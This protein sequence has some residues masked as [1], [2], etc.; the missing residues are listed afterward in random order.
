VRAFA[1]GE[2]VWEPVPDQRDL[3]YPGTA[4]GDMSKLN[5]E[6]NPEHA[7]KVLSITTEWIKHG[8]AK[9]AATLTASG[10]VSGLL[11][12][13]AKGRESVDWPLLAAI[14]LCGA[15]AIAGAIA[16]AW[17]L[18]P[19]IW[20]KNVAASLMYFEHIARGFTIESGAAAYSDSLSTLIVDKEKLVAEIAHQIWSNSQVARRKFFWGNL[21]VSLM[22][23]SLPFLA[24]T[25]IFGAF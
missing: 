15:F 17:A 24:L 16:A 9:A 1:L 3:K 8:E 7:W 21:G 2:R 12:N 18:K 4:S 25:A 11:Y 6:I 14:I 10:L 13:L 22:L 19:R 5:G 20:I 23:A